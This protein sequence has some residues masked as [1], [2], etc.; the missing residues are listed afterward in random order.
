MRR[1]LSVATDTVAADE[2]RSA[3]GRNCQQQAPQGRESSHQL[4]YET[5]RRGA[6]ALAE[7]VRD[8]DRELEE[9]RKL[10]RSY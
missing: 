9:I 2:Q 6:T 1:N 10:V 7:G 8:L 4:V 3:V 5:P